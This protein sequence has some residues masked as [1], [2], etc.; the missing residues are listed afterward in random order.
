MWFNKT[1]Q[2]KQVESV[3]G[4]AGPAHRT[5]VTH[6]HTHR[7]GGDGGTMR[8]R[9]CHRRRAYAGGCCCRTYGG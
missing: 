5:R 4:E 7:R 6:T 9:R 3:E 2:K 1:G 8:R